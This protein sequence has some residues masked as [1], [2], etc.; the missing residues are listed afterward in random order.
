MTSAAE[1][2]LVGLALPRSLPWARF[3]NSALWVGVL[4]SQVLDPL[5]TVD[6]LSVH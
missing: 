4:A 2:A 5:Q 3:S 1:P 6:I